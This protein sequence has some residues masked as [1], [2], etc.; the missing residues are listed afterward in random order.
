M[1]YVYMPPDEP[2][3]YPFTLTDLRHKHTNVTWSRHIDTQTANEFYCYPVIETE[4]PIAPIGQHVVR[5]HPKL[6]DGIWYEMW[7]IRNYTD[8]EIETQW[9]S[10]RFMRNQM[11]KDSDW[12]QLRDAPVD[13]E[14][15]AIYRQS[16]RDITTQTYPFSVV[17]PDVP[18]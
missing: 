15:W 16:L 5:A 7:E 11:L 13:I 10:I 17:W 12:T 1:Y 3:I 14:A 4:R 18:N 8:S 2:P 6:V 9:D